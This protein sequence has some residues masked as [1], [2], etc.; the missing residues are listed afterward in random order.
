MKI[1]LQKD[2]PFYKIWVVKPDDET[3]FFFGTSSK[4]ID[5]ILD[6]L[7]NEFCEPITIEKSPF[8]GWV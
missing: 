1:R 7:E 4:S 5:Q 3:M 6:D 8:Q 2:G